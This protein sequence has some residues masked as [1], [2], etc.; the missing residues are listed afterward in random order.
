MKFSKK[1]SLVLAMLT[2]TVGSTCPVYAAS[3]DTPKMIAPS[4]ALS[5]TT[6]T[7]TFIEKSKNYNKLI[8][9]GDG[10]ISYKPLSTEVV[11]A[12]GKYYQILLFYSYKKLCPDF[13]PAII[14][15]SVF[16][17]NK[18]RWKLISVQPLIMRLGQ[19]CQINKPKTVA[20]GLGHGGFL[21]INK[22]L[23][24]GVYSE[25]AVLVAFSNS[26]QRNHQI[27][28]VWAD[29]GISGA[30]KGVSCK[31]QG[32]SHYAFHGRISFVKV[33]GK[34]W[35][36]VH[37]KR[38]GNCPDWKNARL[39]KATKSISVNIAHCPSSVIVSLPVLKYLK[40]NAFSPQFPWG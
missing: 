6:K 24:T 33:P 39:D 22:G 11:K 18:D 29:K 2:I 30:C 9:G 14:G 3:I 1:I 37:I 16:L 34:P 21:F 12:D 10:K 23:N 38:I 25:S 31:M 7:N 32:T 36:N 5:E 19:Y 13:D 4:T 28:V 26:F 20:L 8:V 35:Y 15:G 40:K 17:W 27:R